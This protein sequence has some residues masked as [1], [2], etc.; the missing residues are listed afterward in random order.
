[1]S[2][3]YSIEDMRKIAELK[4]GKCLSDTYESINQKLK[5]QCKKGH[6]WETKANYVVNCD[7]WCPTCAGKARVTIDDLNKLAEERNGKCLSEECNGNKTKVKWQCENSHVWEATPNN[8]MRGS[9]CPECTSFYNEERCRYIFESLLNKKFIKTR[10]PLDNKFELDGY[11][12]ELNLAFE[13]H[14]IQHYQFVKH[15]HETIDALNRRIEDDKEKELLCKS[16]NIKLIVIP[17]YKSNT[18]SELVGYIEE[19]LLKLDITFDTDIEVDFAGFYKSTSKVQEMH[20]I[21]EQKDGWCL[22]D[23]YDTCR[24][25]YLWQC[26]EGHTWEASYSE[27]KN[28]N[29]WCP[30]CAGTMKLT[31]EDMQNTA[32]DKDGS[33][34]SSAYIDVDKKYLWQCE[35]THEWEASYSSIRRGSWC[36]YCKGLAKRTIEDMQKLACSH[37]GSCISKSYINSH[38]KLQWQCE[39][40]HVFDARPN[41][42]DQG[43]WCPICARLGRSKK[44]I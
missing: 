35:N 37:N 9:W 6:I 2:K 4:G 42:I 31:L 18:Q 25:K 27:I 10:K 36:P 20:E 34:L 32:K 19:F 11:N 26:S 22:S 7:H 3:K 44:A 41:D 38:T 15:F 43:H 16:K 24:S 14:G 13:Y 17:Y 30:H 12:K 21:A 23:T 28:H 5:W 40:G 8:I 39:H 33:C 1:L 29:R